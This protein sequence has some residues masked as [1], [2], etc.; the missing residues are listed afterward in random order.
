MGFGDLG[1]DA[2]HVGA[3]GGQQQG[4]PEGL[5]AAKIED[6]AATAIAGFVPECIVEADMLGGEIAVAAQ[7]VHQHRQIQAD[8]ARKDRIRH[9]AIS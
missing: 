3:V 4:Q 1:V 7:A 9:R 5:A 8:A 6:A 2:E